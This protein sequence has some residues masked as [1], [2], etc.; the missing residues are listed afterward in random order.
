MLETSSVAMAAYNGGR[1]LPEQIDSILDQLGQNDELIVSY[2][3]SSDNTLDILDDYAAH[4][5]RVK[6]FKNTKPGIVGNFNNAISKCTKDIVFISDQDDI[7]MP[8]KREVMREVLNASHADLAIHNVVHI[9]SEGNVISGPL[10]QEYGIRA[11]LLRNFAKPRYSGCCMAFPASTKRIIWPMPDSVVNYDHW[12]GFVCEALGNIV[13]VD[14]I[15]LHH[16]LH[17]DN[18]TVSRRPLGVVLQ[19]RM[20]LLHE[21]KK[22]RGELQS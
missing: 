15:L 22:R 3:I 16:R 11:G 13:F 18:A 10:F 17:G 2:D 1:Y 14:D 9:D 12:I 5:P 6:I 8:G 21:Y 19:Q 7:W 20:N 4:D